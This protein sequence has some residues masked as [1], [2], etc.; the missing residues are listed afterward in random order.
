MCSQLQTT[1]LRN[2]I[3]NIVISWKL[4]NLHQ[5]PPVK[6]NNKQAAG[7]DLRASSCGR[8]AVFGSH[9]VAVHGGLHKWLP[10]PFTESWELF[11]G[12]VSRDYIKRKGLQLEHLW[13]LNHRIQITQETLKSLTIDET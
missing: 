9:P 2:T 11:I 5:I 13:I 6:Q 8:G 4:A 12:A 10:E 7:S 1:I 3:H